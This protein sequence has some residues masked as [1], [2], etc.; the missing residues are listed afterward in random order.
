MGRLR[1]LLQRL[2]RT[3]LSFLHSLH[4]NFSP[5]I[6]TPNLMQELNGHILECELPPKMRFLI[7]A[8]W[9][10]ETFFPFS[11]LYFCLPFLKKAAL[12]SCTPTIKMM[13]TIVYHGS[14]LGWVHKVDVRVGAFLVLELIILTSWLV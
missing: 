11:Y 6:R 8:L 9:P 7:H 10:S 3:P 1:V 14:P 2:N 4:T 5:I 12:D 13:V